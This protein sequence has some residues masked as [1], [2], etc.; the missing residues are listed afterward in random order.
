MA[1]GG[2]DREG[3]VAGGMLRSRRDKPQSHAGG[4]LRPVT[5]I[6]ARPEARYHGLSRTGA[7]ASHSRQNGDLVMHDLVIRGARVFDGLGNR[8]QQQAI[9]IRDGRIVECGD[10]TES[11]AVT[12]DADGLVLCPG[13]VDTHTHYDAQLTW[14]ST[15]SPSPAL[16]V[17]TIVMGNCGFGI[18]PCPPQLRETVASNLSVVEG[19]DLNALA[20]GID[21]GFESFP[22]YLDFLRHRGVYPNTAVL[23]GH[24]VTRT[25]VM[26]KEA[27]ER[28]EPTD[29]EMAAMKEAV[30]EALDAGAIGF[31]SSFSPN[32]LGWN[33]VPMPSTIASDDEVRALAGLMKGRGRGVFQI[34]AGARGTVEVME[35]IANASE[36]S[37]FMTTALTM[38]NEALPGRAHEILDSCAAARERGRRI[39]A[40]V[41]CQPFSMDFTPANP[42]PFYSHD[43]FSAVKAASPEIL[44]AAYADTGFRQAFR[45]NLAAPKP[46]GIFYGDWGKV[47]ITVPAKPANRGLA[48]RTVAEIASATGRDP[49]DVYCDLAVDEDLQ[50]TMVGRFLNTDDNGVAEIL[51]HRSGV[52]SL[53]DAGAHLIFMC[54]AGFATHFL[55]HWVREQGTFSLADGIRRLTSHPAALYGIRD[56]GRI[57]PGAHADLLLFDPDM[58]GMSGPERVGDLPG[59]GLRTIRKPKGIHGVW[60]NGTRVFDGSDYVDMA[61][62]PGAVLDSFDAPALL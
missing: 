13:I 1:S 28:A 31:A 17:T 38:Y 43:A 60:V 34:A 14:D 56:R 59:G 42:Y 5:D 37:V 27:S 58:I 41:T 40:Q 45:D 11:G 46:G 2:A 22:E 57:A 9:G 61:G 52:V 7:T 53:S 15:A 33:G 4:I 48:G 44:A 51:K 32:H 54:D 49:V 29:S 47:E 6:F 8:E 12:V 10:I 39:Y 55:G 16:G 50:T 36:A 3:R 25:A 23:A 24:S 20:R 26:G 30:K 62:P 35:S 18:A 19:M 21:W